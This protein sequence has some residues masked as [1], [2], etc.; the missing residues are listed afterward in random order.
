MLAFI[1]HQVKSSAK[2]KNLIQEPNIINNF[3]MK[4]F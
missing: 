4:E 3:K 2:I 1:L